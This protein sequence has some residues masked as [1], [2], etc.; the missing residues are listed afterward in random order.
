MVKI[1]CKIYPSRYVYSN[2]SGVPMNPTAFPS[3]CVTGLRR[4]AL[5]FLLPVLALVGCVVCPLETCESEET[6]AAKEDPLAKLPAAQLPPRTRRP[7]DSTR[8]QYSLEPVYMDIDEQ[9]YPENASPYTP[10]RLLFAQYL[11]EYL[12]RAGYPVVATPE[13]AVYRVEGNIEADHVSTVTVLGSTVGWKYRGSSVV[14]VLDRDGKELERQ[15]VPKIFQDNAKSE[16][17]AV[18]QLRR[19]MAKLQ[20]DKLSSSSGVFGNPRARVL[21]SSL[22]SDP[23]QEVPLTAEDV[24]E[25]LVDSGFSS[26]AP[27]LDALLDTRLVK[28]PSSYP[29]LK[30]GV[31]PELRVYHV[32]DKALEEIFQK[33]SRM[34]L[35]ITPDAPVHQR[36]RRRI[37]VGWENEWRRFCKPL[38]DS[39]NTRRAKKMQPP[40]PASPRSGGSDARTEGFGE[41]R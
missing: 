32:A 39:P 35:E 19:Y 34:K 15:E 8:D 1:Y 2:S 30:S 20:W 28:L 5:C 40:A 38:A 13:E 24:I 10:D 9:V 4:A 37:V 3:V 6:Q 27:L 22:A 7:P 29:G 41:D 25:E 21:I 11:A 17:S 12:R 31:P 26:V 14:Q 36:L 16:K 23:S 33:V 18:F